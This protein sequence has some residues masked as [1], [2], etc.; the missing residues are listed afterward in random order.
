MGQVYGTKVPN[1]VAVCSCAATMHEGHGPRLLH[2]R[3]SLALEHM[4]C[5]ACQRIE[6][7]CCV[8]MCAHVTM[9]ALATS[10]ACLHTKKLAHTRGMAG[11]YNMFCYAALPNACKYARDAQGGLSPARPNAHEKTCRRH[12]ART[13][14]R[15]V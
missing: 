15:V 3:C 2:V 5:Q 11:M 10:Q 4:P 7:A 9:R 8:C 6:G 1:W 14:C 13:T 12:A